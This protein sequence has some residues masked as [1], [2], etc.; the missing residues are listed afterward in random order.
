MGALQTAHLVERFQILA[1]GDEGSGETACQILDDHAAV[2]LRQFEYFSAP[3]FREHGSKPAFDFL[4]FVTISHL[5]VV[6]WHKCQPGARIY[7]R[8]NYRLL[9][10]ESG[11]GSPLAHG[12]ASRGRGESRPHR[13]GLGRG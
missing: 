6:A 5:R 1:N 10:R 8:S 13:A 11:H 9:E 12:I 3:L 2:T 7:A 4:L